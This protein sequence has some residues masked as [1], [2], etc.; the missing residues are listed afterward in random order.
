MLQ[1]IEI[2]QYEVKNVFPFM[3]AIVITKPTND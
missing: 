3:Q 2:E 1:E